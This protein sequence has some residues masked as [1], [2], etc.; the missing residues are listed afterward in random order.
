MLSEFA[1]S[2]PHDS[3]DKFYDHEMNDSSA[4]ER[5]H[6][7]QLQAL[8]TRPDSLF[9]PSRR[10]SRQE[11]ATSAISLLT[12][13]SPSLVAARAYFLEATTPIE[14]NVKTQQRRRS[15]IEGQAFPRRHSVLSTPRSLAVQL[16]K[17]TFS[18]GSNNLLTVPEAD[19]NTACVKVTDSSDIPMLE[20]EASDEVTPPRRNSGMLCGTPQEFLRQVPFQYTHDHLRDWGYAYL[21]NSATA[22]AFIN[23]ISLRRP[24]MADLKGDSKALDTT[25]LTT[26]RARV[27]PNGKDRKPFLIQRKFNVEELRN[28]IPKAPC[29][30]NKNEGPTT[31]R[32][33]SRT[34]R[35]S[36]QG[37]TGTRRK[38]STNTKRKDKFNTPGKQA[39]PI[40]IEYALHFI[41]VLGALML[42][43]HVRK[44]D[45][46]D[47]PIPHPEAWRD[48][49]T[50]IY[51]GR[52][53]L[54]S[55][56]QENICFLAG[57]A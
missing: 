47:L 36:T 38:D 7:S 43:G 27:T 8:K 1:T 12:L 50:Y 54:T 52:G 28:S 46:I 41:P 6:H 44:G 37:P 13:P 23:T 45:T 18:G 30:P 34:R 48:V 24:S 53:S 56:M 17:F 51:T 9:T 3:R 2:I 35:S 25:D 22:D 32:R 14:Q 10:Q 21:G 16:E 20:V 55:A 57:H 31:L 4:I 49:L 42:S 5:R 33:S 40:H 39:I 29:S 15:L 26:V 19:D 11:S